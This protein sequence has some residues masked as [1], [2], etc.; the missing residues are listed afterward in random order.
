MPPCYVH[1][2][3]I[4]AEGKGARIYH[5][6]KWIMTIP[7]DERKIKYNAIVIGRK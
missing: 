4:D 2:F 7:S 3:R 1:I 5:I 6:Q